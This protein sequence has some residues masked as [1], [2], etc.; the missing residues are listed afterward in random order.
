MHAVTVRDQAEAAG[1]RVETVAERVGGTAHM[2]AQAAGAGPGQDHP[3]PPAAAQDPGQAVGPPHGHQVHHA[4]TLDQD[5]VLAEQMRGDIGDAWLGEQPQY[6]EPRVQA[7]G[8]L[9]LVKL[10]SGRGVAG[11]GG[12]VAHPRR[13]VAVRSAV[14]RAAGVRPAVVRPAVVRPAV[15]RPAVVRPAVV[16][17]AVVRPAVVRPAVV[18]PAMVPLR[19]GSQAEGVLDQRERA[20]PGGGIQDTR[21]REDLPDWGGH[22]AIRGARTAGQLPAAY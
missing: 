16:R 17:P 14:V 22:R 9:V 21:K 18:R 2:P 3:G 19:A 5:E 1:E 15:V 20:L 13:L 7:P 11:G 4:A 6:A 12:D 8:E 10:N